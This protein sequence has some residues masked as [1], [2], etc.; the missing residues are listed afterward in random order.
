MP[1]PKRRRLKKTL[2]REQEREE[3]TVELADE[4]EEIEE[5]KEVVKEAPKKKK[6][7]RNKLSKEE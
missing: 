4:V 7:W 2:L 3:V 6:S 1:S 5:V